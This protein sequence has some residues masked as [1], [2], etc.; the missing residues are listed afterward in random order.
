VK[1]GREEVGVIAQEIR[2]VLPEVVIDTENEDHIL[3]VNYGNIVAV[4]IEAV[5]DLQAEV[6]SLKNK[7]GK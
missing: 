3:A 4:L 2:K 1:N 5:K 7:E 6:K